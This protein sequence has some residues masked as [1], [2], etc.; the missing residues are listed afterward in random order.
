MTSSV[1]EKASPIW[2]TLPSRYYWAE[3][4]YELEKE[5]IFYDTWLYVGRVAQIPNPGDFITQDIVD[6]SVIIVRDKH[7]IINAF[8]NV[9]RH[10]GN[11][12]CGVASGKFK[13]S[14]I[15]CGYHGWTYDL[16]GE[17]IATPNMIGTEGFR[18]GDFP[19]YPVALHF[20]EGGIFVNLSPNPE[21]FD[22]GVGPLADIL[23]RYNL[24]NLEVAERREYHIDANWKLVQENNVECYHCP[25]IHP[26]LCAIQP[27]V[28]RGNIGASNSDGNPLIKGG[29]SF[30]L[31]ATTNRPLIS[32]I[33]PEDKGRF[34][35]TPVWP[36]FFL[37]FLPDHVFTFNVWPTGV[38]TSTVVMEWLFE[39]STIAMPDFDPSDTVEFLDTVVRQ[40]FGICHEVQKGIKSRAHK[41]GVYAPNEFLPH[42]FNEWVRAKV[43]R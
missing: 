29:N 25:S 26:E 34:R 22:P 9:C 33:T 28:R 12:L 16:D 30:T 8:S 40:D 24:A 11:K 39:P 5:R 20:W 19:L 7:G 36:A 43:E 14:A 1:T 13:G 23:A 4:I 2:R 37:G 27:N 6:E 3:D 31:D 10:R 38:Q 15:S 18:K 41:S 17:L 42:E 35:S 32:T 21:P